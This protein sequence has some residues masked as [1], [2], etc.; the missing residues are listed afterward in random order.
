VQG[1]GVFIDDTAVSTGASTSFESD[2]G[3][4]TVTGPPAGSAP[5]GN[6]FIR[7]TA[8]GFPEG[9]AITTPDTIYFGFGFEGIA[10]PASR[11]AVM[12]RVMSYLLGGP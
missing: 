12:Q 10:G 2:L 6:N 3:G 9:A 4:W 1:L 8:A 11:K 7:T 5:N